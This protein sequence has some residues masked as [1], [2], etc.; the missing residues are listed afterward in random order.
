[1]YGDGIDQLEKCFPLGSGQPLKGF[2]QVDLLIVEIGREI[3]GDE[4]PWMTLQCLSEPL[5]PL[6]CQSPLARLQKTDL[7][8]GGT[9]EPR[10]AIQRQPTRFPKR[11]D[12][13]AHAPKDSLGRR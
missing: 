6:G 13:I 8:I 11:S 12:P 3:L 5:K 4:R 7:L 9:R 2:Q 10:Q 1:M